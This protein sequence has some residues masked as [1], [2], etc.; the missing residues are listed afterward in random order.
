MAE[1]D[2]SD[3]LGGE[4][5]ASPWVYDGRLGFKLRRRLKLGRS[6]YVSDGGGKLLNLDRPTRAVAL[7]WWHGEGWYLVIE[8]AKL[9]T[10]YSIALTPLPFNSRGEPAEYPSNVGY[11]ALRG[12]GG[13]LETFPEVFSRVEEPRSDDTRATLTGE[14]CYGDFWSYFESDVTTQDMARYLADHIRRDLG[15]VLTGVPAGN[16]EKRKLAEALA[17]LMDKILY[18]G[19]NKDALAA[20]RVPYRTWKAANRRKNAIDFVNEQYA[21]YTHFGVNQ[22]DLRQADY[23]GYTRPFTMRAVTE[24]S[25]RQ[26]SWHRARRILMP[27][28]KSTGACRPMPRVSDGLFAATNR[29]GD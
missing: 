23:E 6:F 27:C 22:K 20:A 17:D 5:A 12:P 14:W 19:L 26:R 28:W 21:R 7:V 25:I 8:V 15:K 29:P 4:G 11:Y 3:V 24:A 18:H 10:D 13:R 2:G 16:G 1:G 9:L